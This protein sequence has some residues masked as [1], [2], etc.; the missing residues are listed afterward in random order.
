MLC[1][2]YC[3]FNN[4]L[5]SACTFIMYMCHATIFIHIYIHARIHKNTH[6]RTAISFHDINSIMSVTS[7]YTYMIIHSLSISITVLP[8]VKSFAEWPKNTSMQQDVLLPSYNIRT[9]S[10]QY[11]MCCS[12][13]MSLNFLY[14]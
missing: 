14:T 10:T 11:S 13:H 4:I 5:L 3:M 1:Y 2:I 8:Y 12:C 6:T 7:A 9:S